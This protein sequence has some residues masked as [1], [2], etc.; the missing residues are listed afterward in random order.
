MGSGIPT[1]I[2]EKVVVLRY[3]EKANFTK[4]T[5]RKVKLKAKED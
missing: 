2:R 4:D 1:V 3:L 5:G